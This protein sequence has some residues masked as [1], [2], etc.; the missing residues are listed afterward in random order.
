MTHSNDTPTIDWSAIWDSLTWD[1]GTEDRARFQERLRVRAQ[2]YAAPKRYTDDSPDDARAVL[3]FELGGERY[4]VDVMTVR[5]VRTIGRITRVPAIPGFYRGVVNV[6]GQVITV[7][8]LR[9]FFD[10]PA[11]GDDKIPPQELVVVQSGRLEIG[12]LA[13]NVL[14]VM[15]IPRAEIEPIDNVRYALG[16]TTDQLILLDVVHMFEDERLTLGSKDESQT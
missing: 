6:R 13:H 3:A 7:L 16:V 10:M 15:M 9:L 5:R 12:L 1:D 14:G 8:D 11:N 2:Q 4:S